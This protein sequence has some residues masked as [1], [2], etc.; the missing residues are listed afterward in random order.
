MKYPP[1]HPSTSLLNKFWNNNAF[2]SHHSFAS[3]KMRVFALLAC[4]SLV[5]SVRILDAH[6]RDMDGDFLDCYDYI[7]IGGGISGLVVANRLS[8]DPEGLFTLGTPFLSFTDE[9]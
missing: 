3:L 5:S 1:F 6:S 8:E 2:W 9:S 4:I 7:I